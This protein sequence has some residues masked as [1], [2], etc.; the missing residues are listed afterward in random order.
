MTMYDFAIQTKK[1]NN[2]LIKDLENQRTTRDRDKT[3]L[4]H[5]R[6]LKNKASRGMWFET[7]AYHGYYGNSSSSSDTSDDLAKEIAKTL[8]GLKRE[9]IN[10]TIERLKNE[11]IEANKLAADEA[12]TILNEVGK[13]DETSENSQ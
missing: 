12:K 2:G 8:E 13:T 6:G 7:D 4:N 10:R 11:I 3:G 1:R 5:W 9:I